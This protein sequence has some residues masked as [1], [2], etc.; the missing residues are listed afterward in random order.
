[1][2]FR[3][4]PEEDAFRNDVEA[5]VRAELPPG[6]VGAPTDDAEVDIA[7]GRAFS[8]KLAKKGWLAPA[9]PVE[10]GG[11]GLGIIRQMIY[12]EIMAYYRA[13]LGQSWCG[14]QLVG[15]TVMVYGTD[16]QKREHIPSILRNEVWWAQ[17]FSEPNAGSDLASL[18]TRAVV[19]GDDFV[20]NG[21]KTWTS[22]AQ[23]ASHCILLVR[24]DPEAPKHKGVSMLIADLNAPG[25]RVQPLVDM[26]DSQPFNQV[27]F[28]DVRVPRK[29][30]VGELNRGWYV[31]ATTLD[32]ERSGIQRPAMVR[33]LLDDAVAELRSAG[34]PGL[35]VLD[36]SLIR[37]RIAQ[38]RI[39]IE[40][41][42]LISY[43]VVSLQAKGKIP[44]YEASMAKL[45]GSEM[46]QR[47][48]NLLAQ[49]YGAWGQLRPESPRN[50]LQGRV[51]WFYV[52]IIPETI[53]QGS[54]E[55]QRSVIATRGLGLP[56]I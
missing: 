56:R 7:Y 39:E 15:P 42:R 24:T 21:E 46:V 50:R 41:S 44:N 20:V 26:T 32:F 54:S 33:R 40:A 10:Y 36:D 11:L 37:H 30:L 19:G 4:M 48:G 47:F 23:Y 28:E 45:F 17:G 29:N 13:P 8:D 31:A 55:V 34:A 3:F 1:M 5:F 18:Q 12:N 2:D 6:W 38:A 14:I 16:E 52:G 35:R 25:V 9:W 27:I 51:P 53:A 22:G 43:Y 49:M